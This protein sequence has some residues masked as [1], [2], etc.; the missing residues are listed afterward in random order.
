MYQ[1][2]IQDQIP[3]LLNPTLVRMGIAAAPSRQ[4]PRVGGAAMDIQNELGSCTSPPP[5][6]FISEDTRTP[7]PNPRLF[8]QSGIRRR[9][10]KCS[11]CPSWGAPSRCRWG[12]PPASPSP[13][14]RRRRRPPWNSSRWAAGGD[15][16]RDAAAMLACRNSQV[17]C[18]GVLLRENRKGTE[19]SF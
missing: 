12:A 15:W 6:G 11:P 9:R 19:V 14:R 5:L 1:R 16:M 8:S 4:L 10:T 3:E 18:G 2:L 13:P 17:A 7:L